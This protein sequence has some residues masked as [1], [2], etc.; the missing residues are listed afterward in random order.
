MESY[1]KNKIYVQQM[2]WNGSAIITAGKF[3]QSLIVVG[4]KFVLILHL[5]VPG[6]E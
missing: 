5:K 4:Q 1:Q 2:S 6:V 3:F